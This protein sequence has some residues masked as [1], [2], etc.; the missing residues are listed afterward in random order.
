MKKEVKIA[1]LQARAEAAEA[2]LGQLRAILKQKTPTISRP[3]RAGKAAKHTITVVIPDSHGE[4]ID[5]TAAAGMLHDLAELRPEKIL[6]LGDHVDCGGTF[7]SHQRS[8]TNELCESY[9]ADVAAC[10]A[11]L[12]GIQQRA[13]D[14]SI[15]YIEGNHE[16]HVERW[17]ARNFQSYRDA[18]MATDRLGPAAVLGLKERGIRY[19]KSSEFHDGLTV[20][21]TIKRGRVYFTHGLSHSK[22]ADDAHLAAVGSNVIFGHVHR[23]LEVRARTVTSD[24]HLAASPGTLAKLQPLYRHTAVTTWQHGYGLIFTNERTGRF[25]YW[26]VPIFADGTTGLEAAVGALA[27]RKKQR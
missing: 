21:G 22:N 10:N 23:V 15:D 24:G 14:A 1:A 16:A 3:R 5:R 13:P 20:R 2:E 4:H 9:A 18:R 25:A 11:F 27:S 8:Y 6:M 19:W 17:A 26:S 12:D 7:S